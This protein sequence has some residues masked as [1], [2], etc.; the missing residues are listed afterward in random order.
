MQCSIKLFT[1]YFIL[2]NIK[3]C[4]LSSP[5]VWTA[6]GVFD[7]LVCGWIQLHWDAMHVSNREHY[8]HHLVAT[9]GGG[10]IRSSRWQ[11]RVSA[12]WLIYQQQQAI[13]MRPHAL[14]SRTCH[15]TLVM[16]RCRYNSEWSPQIPSRCRWSWFKSNVFA[17]SI[18]WLMTQTKRPKTKFYNKYLIKIPTLHNK[19]THS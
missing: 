18:K 14:C 9:H 7:S 13:I 5:H 6:T 15:A 10:Y 1:F 16:V 3:T 8:K 4:W 2:F 11:E 12:V 17:Y 19:K